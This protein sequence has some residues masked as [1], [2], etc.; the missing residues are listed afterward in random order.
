MEALMIALLL[1]K[2]QEQLNSFSSLELISERELLER[3]VS[4]LQERYEES[5][6]N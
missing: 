4:L 3:E 5:F 2:K 6:E 1:N